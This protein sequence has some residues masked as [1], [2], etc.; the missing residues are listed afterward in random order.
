MALSSLV[1]MCLRIENYLNCVVKYVF[2]LFTGYHGL[3]CSL[4]FGHSLPYSRFEKNICLQSRQYEPLTNVGG[5][6]LYRLH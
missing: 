3:I 4:W 5:K 1:I 2:C 6:M